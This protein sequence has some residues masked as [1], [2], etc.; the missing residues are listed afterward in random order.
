MMF[1]CPKHGPQGGRFLSPDLQESTLA[2]ERHEG[3]ILSVVHLFEGQAAFTCY[4]SRLFAEKYKVKDGI[5]ELPLEGPA[6]VHELR[7]CCSKC[8]DEAQG[9]SVDGSFRWHRKE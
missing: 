7:G 3:E 1:L 5:D 6:W 2:G 4:V 9:G 8:F